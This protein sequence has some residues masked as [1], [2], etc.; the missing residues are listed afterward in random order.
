MFV[1]GCATISHLDE[2]LTLKS[3]DNSQTD[4]KRS[5]AR[6]EEGFALLREDVDADN[7]KVGTS[8]RRIIVKYGEP[9]ISSTLNEASGEEILLYR[10]PTRYF[11]SDKIYL[12]FDASKK[13]MRIEYKPYTKAD[14]A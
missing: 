8:K 4:M 2:L 7:L 12:Y 14:P 5:I 10:R 9:I 6:Q 3:M 13:L 1:S 11:D